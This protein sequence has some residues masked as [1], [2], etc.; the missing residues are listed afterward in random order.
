MGLSFVKSIQLN[1]LELISRVKGL[2]VHVAPFTKEEIDHAIKIMPL[3]KAP[4]PD[5]FNWDILKKMLGY[6]FR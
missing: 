1:L 2:D 3:D 4:N 5:G 6:N